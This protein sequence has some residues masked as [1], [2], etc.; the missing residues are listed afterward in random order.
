MTEAV[1]TT[2]TGKRINPLRLKPE[3]IDLRDIAHHLAQVNRFGGA[4]RFPV[5][6]AQ[7]SLFVSGLCETHEE[8]V[9]GLLHD[10]TEAYMGDIIHWMK[11]SSVFDMYRVLERDMEKLIWRSFGVPEDM[12]P[13]VQA[14]D[15]MICRYEAYHTMPQL[16]VPMGSA[17]YG[18][19]VK[20]WNLVNDEEK[21]KVERLV[22]YIWSEWAW[23]V[24]EDRFLQKCRELSLIT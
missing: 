3:D 1:M 17:G 21:F 15:E 12:L 13:A 2:F 4:S 23:Y 11:K 22:P 19:P 24:A 9:Q 8:K 5:S 10:A 16:D 6:V 14:A 7:H 18:G 20:S